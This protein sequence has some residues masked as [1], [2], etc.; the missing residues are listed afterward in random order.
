MKTLIIALNSKYIHSSLAPWYLKAYCGDQ[1]GE[2]KVAEFT[3]N[4][5]LDAVLASVYSEQPDIVAFSCYIWNITDVLKIAQ[6]LKKVLPK[7]RI[8]LG[9]PEVSFDS[10]SIISGNCY[11]DYII[12]GEGEN[13]FKL[14]LKYLYETKRQNYGSCSL[15]LS[16]IKGLIYKDKKAIISNGNAELIGNLDTIPS[17]YTDEMLGRL[18]NRIAYFETSRGCPF[19]CSYCLSSTFEGVRYFSMER[20]Q[21]DLLK[22]IEAGV[23]QVKFVDRTFNCNKKRAK[24]IFRFVVDKGGDTNF[25]FEVAADLFDDE[26]LD[27]LAS[28]P[29]GRVQFEIGVQT[30]NLETLDAINRRT[31]LAKVFHNVDRLIGM[32]NIHIHL[33]LIAGLPLEDF[34][35]FRKSFDEVYSL[36]PHH[37]QLGFLKMLKGSK[38]REEASEYRYRFREY[39]P[40][41][42]LCNGYLTFDEMT[43]LKGI[44]EVLERYYNSSRFTNSI[45]YVINRYF[46]S[47]FDFYK[48]FYKFNHEAGYLERSISS[49]QLYTV[50]LE[51]LKGLT[52]EDEILLINELLKLDYLSSD[53]S[54][55]L[56]EG[57]CRDIPV[58]FK[59]KCFEFLK[60]EK[61]ISTYIPEFKGMPA[62][63]IYKFVHFE[64]FR[65]DITEKNNKGRFEKN[66]CVVLFNYNSKDRVTGLYDCSKVNLEKI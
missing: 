57:I 56:P 44:E 33:D 40:Y 1:F 12:I 34:K 58:G 64:V 6:D 36:R 24:E 3:I 49:R 45:D 50:F 51:F 29:K 61:N 63:H 13:T 62:K 15:S 19:S 23:K 55:N 26:M 59:E 16:E 32:K 65:Y 11:I 48:N 41:E 47:A 21:R 18:G 30:T 28:A 25:H 66:K 54:N 35:S 46:H 4:H 43:V 52:T 37:L 14:L 7:V 42:V 60:N 27:I 10:V 53:N 20:V 39:P 38:I 17:P 22:L 31:D 9:G 8:V 2:I 5:N